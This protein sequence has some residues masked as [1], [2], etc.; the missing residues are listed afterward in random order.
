[1]N[2]LETALGEL[3]L[4]QSFFDELKAELAAEK[5]IGENGLLSTTGEDVD[6]ELEQLDA[7]EEQVDENDESEVDMKEIS[8]MMR[9]VYK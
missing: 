7:E 3:G 6:D 8:P 9:G 1:M 4:T 5:L 2:K